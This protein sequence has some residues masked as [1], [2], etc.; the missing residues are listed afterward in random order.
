MAEIIL[1]KENFENEVINSD[2]PVL[3]D[4]LLAKNRHGSTGRMNISYYPE[5]NLFRDGR[6]C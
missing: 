4:I 3:V 5:T 6:I 1:T 2:K